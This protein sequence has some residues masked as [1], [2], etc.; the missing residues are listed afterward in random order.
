[1]LRKN[2]HLRYKLSFFSDFQ[3]YFSKFTFLPENIRQ[4]IPTP[5]HGKR[6][7]P[8]SKAGERKASLWR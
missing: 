2:F 1:L 3:I 6:N 4:R 8:P 7:K 5:V